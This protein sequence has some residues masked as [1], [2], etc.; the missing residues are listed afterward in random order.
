MDFVIV[1]PKASTRHEVIWVIVDWL[2]KSVHFILLKVGCSLEKQA[3]T[4]IKAI[5]RLHGVLVS[6]LSNID[7]R[8]VSR[9]WRSLHEALGVRLPFSTAFHL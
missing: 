7:P 1:I 6:I 8:F 9:F 2:P 5:V 4:Y 3:Q